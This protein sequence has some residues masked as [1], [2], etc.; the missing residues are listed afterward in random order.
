MKPPWEDVLRFWLGDLDANG[1]ADAEHAQRWWKKDATFDAL[2]RERFLSD[3]RAIVARQ[4]DD[5]LNTPH[6]RLAT[7]IVIDQFSRN[8]FRGTAEMFASD[9]LAVRATLAGIECGHEQK[10][11]G[12]ERVFFHMPLMHSEDIAHQERCVAIFSKLAEQIGGR[13]AH[14]ARYAVQHRDIVARF[15]RFPH[16]NAILG[17]PSTP[18]E[19][20]FLEQPGSSF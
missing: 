4:R 15:G 8:M 19:V 13:A 5:W 12:D 11:R 16:R 2:I 14:N 10:L 18:E 20:A 1:A 9:A 3:H 17:R 7:I 6:G